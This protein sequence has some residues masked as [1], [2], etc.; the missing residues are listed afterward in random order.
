MTLNLPNV[1]NANGTIVN[2][3]LLEIR[4]RCAASIIIVAGKVFEKYI[5][6]VRGI[7]SCP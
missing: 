7:E 2:I 4:V 1:Q 6:I 5:K 3:E